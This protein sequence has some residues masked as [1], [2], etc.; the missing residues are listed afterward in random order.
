MYLTGFSLIPY[1]NQNFW[2]IIG[3]LDNEMYYEFRVCGENEYGHG[4]WSEV[5]SGVKTKLA[6]SS[7]SSQA[8]SPTES[9]LISKYVKRM[10]GVGRIAVNK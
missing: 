9:K 2:T 10:T 3:N 7:S 6:L 8:A 4:P 5:L 1:S